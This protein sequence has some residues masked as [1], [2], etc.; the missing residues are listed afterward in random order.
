MDG[1]PYG[2]GSDRLDPVVTIIV[3][4]DVKACLRV[5]GQPGKVKER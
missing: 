3:D 5:F 2:S 4:R 1:Y